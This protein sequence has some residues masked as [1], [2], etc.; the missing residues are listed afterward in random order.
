MVACEA[1]VINSIRNRNPL[2]F[3]LTTVVLRISRQC[4][5]SLILEH[6]FIMGK[7]ENLFVGGIARVSVEMKQ[8]S[9]GSFNGGGVVFLV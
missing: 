1:V 2:S 5:S 7:T 4:L 8:Y 6:E 3:I 9:L